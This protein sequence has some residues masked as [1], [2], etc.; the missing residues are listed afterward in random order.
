MSPRNEWMRLLGATMMVMALATAWVG[1]AAA[2]DNSQLTDSLTRAQ[3][4]YDTLA[5]SEAEKEIEDALALAERLGMGNDPA[6]ADLHIFMGI[7]RQP[8]SGDDAAAAA[9]RQALLVNRDVQLP[10]DYATPALQSILDK[11]RAA[12][13]PIEP[14]K[15]D[16]PVDP[17]P[18]EGPALRHSPVSSGYAGEPLVFD[19]EIP[20]TVP[21]YRVVLNYRRFGESDY[22]TTEMAPKGDTGFAFTLP[23]AQVCGSR[24]DY[25]IVALDRTSAVLAEEGNRI[26]PLSVAVLGGSTGCDGKITKPIDDPPP[27]DDGERQYVF[28]ML[29]PGTGTGLVLESSTPLVNPDSDVAP[30]VALAPLHLNVE[31]GVQ[32]TN[33]LHLSAT[34]RNQFVFL[35]DGLEIEPIFGGKLRW[36]FDNEGDFIMYTGVGGGFGNVR[37]LITVTLADGQGTFNDTINHGPIHASAGFGFGYRATP[38]VALVFDIYPMVLFP[39]VSA[40]VDL[41]AG[42]RLSF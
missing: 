12:L 21:V 34:Y 3:E 37:H 41:N 5:L 19:A 32:I 39:D 23:G 9:F 8:L 42:L 25:Y 28:F 1:T 24:I 27:G 13:P 4:F 38:N 30:G 29:S 2:Q 26:S 33:S 17:P 16:P 11:E 31:L 36:W 7:V 40:H 10:T 18:V 15:P 35:T 14:I 20:P 22:T 6:V